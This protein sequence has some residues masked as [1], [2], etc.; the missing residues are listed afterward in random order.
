MGSPV[1]QI[2]NVVPVALPE[3]VTR[4]LAFTDVRVN[5]ES[6]AVTADAAT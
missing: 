2:M 4:R 6:G 3:L 5:N 1:D